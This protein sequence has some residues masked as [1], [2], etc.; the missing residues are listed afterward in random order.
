[1]SQQ[2]PLNA[3]HRQ[4][5]ARMVDFGGWDMPI[6]YGSQIEEHHA[7]RRDAGMFDVSHMTVI[8]L[9]GDRSRDFLRHLFANDV[10]RLKTPGKALYTCMLNETGGVIDDLIVYW[11]AGTRYRIVSNASTRDKDLAW[12]RRHAADYAVTVTERPEM[13][14]IA[15]QGPTARE[16]VHGLLST[17][18]S[19]SA[20][21]LA[22][23]AAIEGDGL[24]I[25]RTGYTGEDGYEIVLPD[26]EVVAWWQKLVDAGVRPC[27]LGARDTL[28]L[29]AGMNLY[30]QDM[31]ETT[32]P[33]ESGLAW[34]L[35]MKDE[36]AF[37]GRAAL[38]AQLDAGVPQRLVGLVLEDK[39]VLRH[40][41]R[42]ITDAGDGVITSGTFSPTA[43]KSIALARVPR[44]ATSFRVDIRGRELPARAVDIPFVRDGQARPGL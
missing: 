15:V 1:M 34:T 44:D 31:D 40:D 28:R 8:D 14:I 9:D 23:F 38:Q 36:R 39:G 16:R 6:N 37:L 29:E 18:T 27:G 10:A 2:T 33:L 12:I 3:V 43:G 32:T 22:R 25:A 42:V 5:G 11:L 26:S 20:T 7:V 24:F 19:Q 13:A 17:A 4:L 35:A 30:G 21:A 41:Q